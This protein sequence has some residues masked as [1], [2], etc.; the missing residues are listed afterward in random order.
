MGVAN[1]INCWKPKNKVSKEESLDETRLIER[2]KF[3]TS[4][5]LF[6]NKIC[7]KQTRT[8]EMRLY[9]QRN[10]HM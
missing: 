5:F 2:K 8:T 1:K 6:W 10:L 3:E 4:I 9:L 7:F